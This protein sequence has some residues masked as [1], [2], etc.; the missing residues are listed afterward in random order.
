VAAGQ[1]DQKA[2]KLHAPACVEV[3]V[4]A[5]SQAAL[6]ARRIPSSRWALGPVDA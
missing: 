4:V 2:G 6:A 3:L 5:G 1:P